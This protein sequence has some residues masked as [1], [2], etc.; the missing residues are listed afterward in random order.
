MM[1]CIE[2]SGPVTG[3]IRCIE[4]IAEDLT[5]NGE[6]SVL[7][8]LLYCQVNIENAVLIQPRSIFNSEVTTK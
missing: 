7:R 6:T 8:P 1:D 4:V 3:V 2:L 5:L